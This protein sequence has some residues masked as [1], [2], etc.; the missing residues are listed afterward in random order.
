MKTKQVKGTTLLATVI[1]IM[2]VILSSGVAMISWSR[3]GYKYTVK[4]T[5]DSRMFY[6]ADAGVKYAIRR[7]IND[8][9]ESALDLSVISNDFMTIADSYIPGNEF[10]ITKYTIE[11]IVTNGLY[12]GDVNEIFIL[13]TAYDIRC[14]VAKP[15]PPSESPSMPFNNGPMNPEENVEAESYSEVSSILGDF[16]VS[17]F[18]F[19]LYYQDMV[20]ELHSGSEEVQIGGRVHSNKSMYLKSWGDIRF[21]DTVTCAGGVYYSGYAGNASRTT[22]RGSVYIKNGDGEYKDMKTGYSSALD[23]NDPDWKVKSLERWDENIK[24]KDHG[25]GTIQLP[26]ENSLTNTRVVIDPDPCTNEV[27]EIAKCRF[28]NKAG[29]VITESGN[30]YE[31]TGDITNGEYTTRTFLD[32]ITN[33][34]WAVTSNEFYNRRNMDYWTNDT[35]LGMVRPIDIDIG[36]FNGWVS[37]QSSL[38]FKDPSSPRVGILYIEQTNATGHAVRIS[39]AEELYPL[40]SGFTLATPNPLYVKGDYNVKI[41]GTEDTNYPSA[42]LSDAMTVLSDY[43]DDEDNK[44]WPWKIIDPRRWPNPTYHCNDACDTT[45]NSAIMTGSAV[46]GDDELRTSGWA[47]NLIRYLE[48]WK[49]RTF[50][51]RGNQTCLWKSK[52]EEQPYIFR[53]KTDTGLDPWHY[54]W[55]SYRVFLYDENLQKRSPPGFDRFYTYRL[56]SWKKIH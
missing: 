35:E 6:I 18:Q 56:L 22:G 9:S 42:L 3:K 49:Y 41:G 34:S 46:T 21:L 25:I 36:L 50:T 53:S 13:E 31:Q 28:E 29:L 55:P 51:L 1:V 44:I 5:E 54:R 14:Q 48:Y 19:G 40:S 33:L 47:N 27:Y 52:Y 45:I 37:N 30:L 15:T 11:E 12:S 20:L 26:F 2:S 23:S 38:S 4:K 43:W 8:A 24:T 16:S 10:E 39:N 7:I 17:I 32:N